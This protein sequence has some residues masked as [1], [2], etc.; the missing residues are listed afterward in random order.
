[1][2]FRDILDNIRHVLGGK[3]P[4]EAR[5]DRRR[6][7]YE[8]KKISDDVK[9]VPTTS[10]TDY[11][12][13]DTG[14]PTDKKGKPKDTG[15][16]GSGTSGGG[17]TGGT[18]SGG[19][20]LSKQRQ[21]QIS[22]QTKE[23][24][25]QEKVKTQ[26]QREKEALDREQFEEMKQQQEH[27]DTLQRQAGIGTP[28]KT[29]S[30][31]QLSQEEQQAIRNISQ[32]EQR[33][34][35]K[36]TTISR[37][38]DR[39]YSDYSSPY[40][41]SVEKGVSQSFKNI[42]DI[43]KDFIKGKRGQ[44]L[45]GD[46]FLPLRL[47]GKTGAQ[48]KV[49]VDSEG[50]IIMNAD[51]LTNKQKELLK[52]QGYKLTT[53][54]KLQDKAI[55]EAREEYTNKAE[56]IA[57]NTQKD[58]QRYQSF[59][60]KQVN[61]GD[62]SQEKAQSS[63]KS[64]RQQ[65]IKDFEKSTKNIDISQDLPFKQSDL[66]QTEGEELKKTGS[67]AADVTAGVI[68]GPAA[69]GYFTGKGAAKS[70][71][72]RGGMGDSS[73]SGSTIS[74][75]ETKELTFY[76]GGAGV[77]AGRYLKNV[78]RSILASDLNRLGKQKIKYKG[79]EFKGT[80]KSIV[81]SVGEQDYKNLLKRDFFVE[82]D[83]VKSGKGIRIMPEGKVTVETRGTLP[84]S[85]FGYGGGG[86]GKGGGPAKIL[87]RQ[88]FKVGSKSKPIEELGD[89]FAGGK[90]K[91]F[92]ETKLSMTYSKG[93]EK[94]ILKDLERSQKL[95][96]LRKSGVISTEKPGSYAKKVRKRFQTLGGDEYQ[97]AFGVSKAQRKGTGE[98]GGEL[99]KVRELG[100]TKKGKFRPPAVKGTT[101]VIE[102][103]KTTTEGFTILGPGQSKTGAKYL[104]DLYGKTGKIEKNIMKGTSK[105]AGTKRGTGTTTK[106][107]LKT[108]QKPFTTSSIMKQTS[109]QLDTT[110]GLKTG[111][112]IVAPTIIG[113]KFEQKIQNQIKSG[114]QA[115]IMQKQRQRQR[116]KIKADMRT[117][118][119]SQIESQMR[120]QIG[121]K[122]QA[123]MKMR[124]GLKTQQL[125]NQPRVRTPRTSFRLPYGAI[126]GAGFKLPSVKGYKPPVKK[127][128]AIPYQDRLAYT[129]G[130]TARALGIQREI[131]PKQLQTLSRSS[132]GLRPGIKRRKSTKKTK[133]R[134]K[135]KS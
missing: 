54:G 17:F 66:I 34:V 3:S 16:G 78:E 62:L 96:P 32:E 67:I 95:G 64:Y 87:Q 9:A 5:A 113:G 124:T 58:I 52:E 31:L 93:Q 91:L 125:I 84:Y 101:E 132:L 23:I 89:E 121:A 28:D 10:G 72:A 49:V 86:F 102:M 128:K 55:A 100:V 2:G 131:S 45:Y 118:I 123:K 20:G 103:P 114:S 76:F 1:M 97:Q 82:G 134:R 63:L 33:Q 15:G 42:A 6:E 126:G 133:K 120:T 94:Q 85:P 8:E 40:N 106:L 43:P 29:P 24:K 36:Q 99:Y 73:I 11:Y 27:Q 74:P 80:D 92:P 26:A 135:K 81:K 53:K 4:S 51:K 12:D 119:E 61:E 130:F 70:S 88:T 25:S 110:L 107:D 98:F 60:Q 41:Q 77:E 108:K 44:E 13:K 21:Q 112:K 109:E 79:V 59:L 38:K 18:S 129:P 48:K 37:G 14:L 56:K 83:V 122:T 104:D 68:G 30:E 47:S 117:N 65:K 90:T 71:K 115:K 35:G 69:I 127:K 57:Q 105:G 39:G 22:E 116:A 75:S 19:G 111:N 50:N 7:K 46:V